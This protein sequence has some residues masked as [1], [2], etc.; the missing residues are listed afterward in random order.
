MQRI[1]RG[2]TPLSPVC[3]LF[4]L[5][6]VFFVTTHRI[7]LQSVADLVAAAPVASGGGSSDVQTAL[8]SQSPPALAMPPRYVLS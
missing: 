1:L 3:A 4:V 6:A 5:V 2:D 8:G 7:L